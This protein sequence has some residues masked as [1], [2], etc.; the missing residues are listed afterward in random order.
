MRIAIDAFETNYRTKVGMGIYVDNLLRSLAQ[1]DT[2]NEYFLY[3]QNPLVFV[4]ELL[5]AKFH[6]RSLRNIG[7]C[8]SFWVQCRLPVELF[9]KRPD[10]LH[11][12]AGQKIP[13]FRLCPTLVTIHDVAFLK[14]KEY[15]SFGLGLRSE[16]F[17]RYAA[18]HADKII[19]ISE[20][21][22]K[23]IMH[24]YNISE[25][26]IEVVY[27]GVNSIFH[28][29]E[30]KSLLFSVKEKYKINGHYVLFTG[31]LQPRKN[32]PRLIRAF[33]HVLNV[34]NGRV[35]LVISGQKGWMYKEIFETT[36]REGVS[37]KV[38]FTG[39]V[40]QQELVLLMNAA[41]L[42]ILPSLYE[43]FGMPLLEAMSCGAPVICS[44]VSSMPEVVADAGLC[45]DPYSEDSI[46]QTM[47]LILKNENLKKELSS[48]GR[49]R[50]KL[51][52]WEKAAAR[53]L[54]IYEALIKKEAKK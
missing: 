39:Y 20:S 25:D 42:L 45:C 12:P 53:T 54:A 50:A 52:S 5:N 26:R 48:R 51:F 29:I 46:A 28:P 37:E 16:M 7:S 21:T 23:D 22:K 36:K 35:S 9:H 13:F 49:I 10:V 41:E 15:F 18:K 43:G 3:A 4:P 14:F 6:Y 32:I 33:R 40:P 31:V 38:I 1:I 47:L 44:N 27:H 8:R 19:A 30:D 2:A 34:F 11:I 24:Y 17:T